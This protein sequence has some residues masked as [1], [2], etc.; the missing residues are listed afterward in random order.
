MS[1]KIILA[2]GAF[3]MASTIMQGSALAI[4]PSPG[5]G[6]EKERRV[7][8]P[9]RAIDTRG[10]AVRYIK[11]SPFAAQRLSPRGCLNC[12]ALGRR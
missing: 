12:A 8:P 9:W 5:P 1:N 10:N 3:F 2:I 7:L 4:E 11:P 6:Y